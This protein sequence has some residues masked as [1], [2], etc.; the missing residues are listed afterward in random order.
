MLFVK[1][2][3]PP[4]TGEVVK[5]FLTQCLQDIKALHEN[6]RPKLDIW[7]VTDEGSNLL[8]ALRLM[9]NEGINEK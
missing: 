5:E 4:V 2:L 7:A 9:K 8:K 1:D 6:G 3:Q